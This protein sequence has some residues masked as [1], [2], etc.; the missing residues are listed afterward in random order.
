[1]IRIA[2]AD[3]ADVVAVSAHAV[4]AVWIAA[5]DRCVKTVV[6]QHH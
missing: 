3:V 4:S 2:A 6:Q 1:M 5:V